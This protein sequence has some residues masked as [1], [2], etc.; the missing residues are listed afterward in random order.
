MENKTN[1]YKDVLI[2]A[3]GE[4]L[5]AFLTVLGFFVADLAF[6]TGFSYS[7]I[8]GAILGFAVITANHLFLSISV[9]RAVDKYLAERGTREMSDEEA[10]KFTN[11]HSMQI[12]NSVK[13]SYII[14]TFT[15]LATLVAAFLLGNIFN[16]L[17]TVIPM[18]A[19]R[20][21]LTLGEIF[22][23]KHDPEPDKSKFIKY[24]NEDEEKE[25]E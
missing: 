8:L 7:V 25:V 3:I 4:A 14:R 15:M 19:Y 2:L 20:P 13:T 18:L 24:D 9:N 17:A 23:R 16:P 22:R 1:T 10:E 11:E 21:V 6:K 12:Q 5:A